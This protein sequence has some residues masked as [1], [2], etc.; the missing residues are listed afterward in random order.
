MEVIHSLHYAAA[1]AVVCAS[2]MRS[3]KAP[4]RSRVH[5]CDIVNGATAGELVGMKKEHG[6]YSMNPVASRGAGRLP[7]YLVA[8]ILRLSLFVE[9]SYGIR[10][11]D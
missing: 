11:T 4:S 2:R 3:R 6:I 1:D 10:L 5:T 8:S 9:I 7:N